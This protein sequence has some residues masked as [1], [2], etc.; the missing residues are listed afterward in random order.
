MSRFAAVSAVAL[1]AALLAGC[2]GEHHTDAT[3]KADNSAT[4]VPAPSSSPSWKW[5]PAI[6][7]DIDP[8]T[9]VTVADAEKLLGTPLPRTDVRQDNRNDK[10]FPSNSR[11]VVYSN[12]KGKDLLTTD[13][14]LRISTKVIDK[15]LDHDGS[16]DG[17]ND[18]DVIAYGST[19]IQ[20]SP[21]TPD[22]IGLTSKSSAQVFLV[23]H[24]IVNSK[25]YYPN[26][27]KHD[28]QHPYGVYIWADQKLANGKTRAVRL[29]ISTDGSETNR[30]RLLALAA[31][32]AN[33]MHLK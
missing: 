18:T 28:L 13:D 32:A 10:L 5:H 3:D 1:C 25:Q 19:G 31:K 24:G 21:L 27:T 30:T 29:A 23:I 20:T 11:R 33:R 9:L 12:R 7:N 4:S 22:Q 15:S 26:A 17:E 2:S 8:R 14:F 6:A 16:R